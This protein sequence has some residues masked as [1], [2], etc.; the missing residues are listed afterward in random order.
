[1]GYWSRL[2]GKVFLQWLAPR[3]RLRWI[4]VGC[5][6]G[7]FSELLVECCEPAGIVGIDPAEAQLAF[8]RTRPA[9]RLAEFR[10][11]DAMSLPFLDGE[12]DAAIMAHVIFFVPNPVKGIAEMARVVCPGG[13]VAAYAWDHPGGGFPGEIIRA[14]M[15]AAGLAPARPPSSE[16][17]RMETLGELWHR[18]GLEAIEA[19]EIRVQ[20]TFADFDEFWAASLF[21]TE[22]LIATM[23]LDDAKGLKTRVK[24]Q[25]EADATGR[26][27]SRAR[28]NAIKGR[29]RD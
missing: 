27:T 29:V 12:F 9:A 6:S 3:P 1:M 13:I 18:A 22:P 5:G 11:G 28:A 7:A 10:Q 8:A 26:I 20:R 24:A 15:R 16:A 21:G 2:T 4:D 25:L 14:E 19:R 23:G 17:S